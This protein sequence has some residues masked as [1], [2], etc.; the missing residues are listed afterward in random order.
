MILSVQEMVTL[1]RSSVNVQIPTESGDTITDPEFLTMSDDDLKLFLKLGISRAFPEVEDFKELPEGS[2]YPVVLLAKIELYRKLAVL[3]AHKVDLGADNNNYLK[4]SQR[5]S[6]YTALIESAKEEYESWLEHEGQGT[7][8]TF[9]V[10]LSNRHY[11]HRNYEKQSTPKVTLFIDQITADSV[12]FHWKVSKTSHF[13]RFKAYISEN[14]II[15]LSLEGMTADKK[16]IDGSTLV[17]S[18]SNIRNVNHTVSGLKPET[19]Y[20]LAV[21]SIERN[22][23]FGFDEVPFDTLEEF[24][25]EEEIQNPTI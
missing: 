14:P 18:T 25:D 7:V 24:E 2:E 5:F 12:T 6:H 4:L 15:D 17:V 16:V 21:F 11:T 23:V 1:L 22:Q 20:Y 3:R 19:T 8:S 10:L 13:G 9:D